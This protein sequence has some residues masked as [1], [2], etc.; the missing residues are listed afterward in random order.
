[1]TANVIIS[2]ENLFQNLKELIENPER[3]IGANVEIGNIPPLEIKLKGD[4]FN[5]SL[6]T[7]VM[8]GLVEFQEAINRSYCI[9][10][11]N[12]SNLKYLEDYERDKLELVIVVNSGCTELVADFKDI[13]KNIKEFCVDMT[14]NQ[15]IAVISLFLAAFLAYSMVKSVESVLIEKSKD[16]T[17]I[18][19]EAEHTKQLLGSQE[20]VLKAVELGAAGQQQEVDAS[21]KADEELKNE[22]PLDKI[23][24][25]EK[26]N[27]NDL[28][29]SEREQPT[30]YFNVL[31]SPSS[32]DLAVIE[33][34]KA[35]YPQAANAF[36]T[37]SHGVE[38]LIKS[39]SQADFVRYN[40]TVEMSGDM[41]AKIVVKPR[42]LADKVVMKDDFRVLKVDSS[43]TDIRRT[44][45][46]SPDGTEFYANFT[47][48]S[49]GKEKLRKL[50][51]AFWGYHPIDLS[52]EAKKSKDK[53]KDA[54]ITQVRDVNTSRSFREDDQEDA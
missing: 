35:Q 39:T 40:N 2:D 21:K 22:E 46:R 1:M 20:N 27:L 24:N 8:K 37:M 31:S 6:T 53:I 18:A 38:R 44:L 7:T 28:D 12:S 42:V 47:D 16:Q 48:S 3:F 10:R 51:E 50:N 34:V 33:Q 9:A 52:I 15:K 25:E 5:H 45:L 13:V 11:Y 14:P 49:M 36:N 54:L 26:V 4:Q 23:I 29:N 32:E 41:A 19:L 30:S 17:S 43:S